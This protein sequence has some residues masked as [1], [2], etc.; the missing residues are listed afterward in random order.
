[1]SSFV[2]Q[3]PG[4]LDQIMMGAGRDITQV[5]ESY[6]NH[7]TVEK[8]VPINLYLHCAIVSGMCDMA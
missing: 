8:W 7:Q 2:S 1:M 3:H 5:F 6:H 4:G